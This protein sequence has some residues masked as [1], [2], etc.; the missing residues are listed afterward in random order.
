[1]AKTVLAAGTFDLVHPGHLHYLREAKKLGD[2]LCVVVARDSNVAKA[3]GKSPVIDEQHR[4]ELVK[5]LRF[6]DEAF[7]GFEDDIFKTVEKV[8]PDILA[9]GYDQKP[10][11]KEIEAELKKRGLNCKIVRISPYK[12]DVHKSSK[13]KEKIKAH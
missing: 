2:Q 12:E 4:L 13:I 6:V 1:M 5:A 9:L 7:L 11:D 8:K 10:S 3:K